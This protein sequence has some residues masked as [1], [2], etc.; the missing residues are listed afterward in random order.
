MFNPSVDAASGLDAAANPGAAD[1]AGDAERIAADI[2]R[3]EALLAAA[4]AVPPLAVTFFGHPTPPAVVV[5]ELAI[6]DPFAPPPEPS[7]FEGP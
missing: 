6:P 7:A 1:S 3:F 5:V 2:R 4:E